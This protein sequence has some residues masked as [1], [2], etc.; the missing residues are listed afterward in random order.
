MGAISS[1]PKYPAAAA[2]NFTSVSTP[3]QNSTAN[4]FNISN[5]TFVAST[6]NTFTTST[7]H[8][9]KQWQYFNVMG[10]RGSAGNINIAAGGVY[11]VTSA[12]GAT[13]ITTTDY[14]GTALTYVPNTGI[15]Q[16]GIGQPTFSKY[17]N[18]KW[19]VGTNFGCLLSSDDGISWTI[20]Q[21]ANGFGSS[22]GNTPSDI[23]FGNG[24]YVVTSDTV[25]NVVTTTDLVNFTSRSAG[26]NVKYCVEWLPS[27]NLFVTGGSNGEIMSSPDGITWTSRYTHGSG[28][29]TQIVSNGTF[30]VANNPSANAYITSTDG[31]TWTARNITSSWFMNYL[32][33]DTI[34]SRW[35]WNVSGNAGFADTDLTKPFD[36]NNYLPPRIQDGTAISASNNTNT[37]TTGNNH[38][39]QLR[40][41]R[42]TGL[43]TSNF[44]SPYTGFVEIVKSTSF[45]GFVNSQGGTGAY[46]PST[47]YRV[48]HALGVT[49]NQSTSNTY[50]QINDA[51]TQALILSLPMSATR[52]NSILAT[53]VTFQ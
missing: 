33:W 42:P 10:A 50:F 9:I 46:V 12:P 4:I 23:T 38:G 3:I 18:N 2:T 7:T 51:G 30:F 32:W 43:F 14:L 29:I 5:I 34:S 28:S 31:T 6:S 11:S 40:Y 48:P 25:G 45:T 19:I 39:R 53:I 35:S 15:L 16:L 13:T 17:V 8:N 37:I 36:S 20:G 47:V 21:V 27:V 22:I 24:V 1:I 52:G 41:Y 26:A 44:P 49:N